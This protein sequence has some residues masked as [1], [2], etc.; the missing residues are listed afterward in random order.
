MKLP[1]SF[2]DNAG[3]IANGIPAVAISM[4]PENEA[5]A[6]QFYIKKRLIQ[7]K[8]ELISGKNNSSISSQAESKGFYRPE[9]W[10]LIHTMN[11]D[12]STLTPESPLLMEKILN[13]L[14]YL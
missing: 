12:V 8:E 4:L 1:T 11:D 13:E 7:K 6:Y 3:F 9:T 14:L 10:T 2:S 5:K